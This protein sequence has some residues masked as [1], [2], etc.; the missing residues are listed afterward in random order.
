MKTTD[1]NKKITSSK[2]K[3]NLTKQFGANVNLDKYDREQLEDIRN[4]LRTRI[5]QQEGHAGINDLLTNETYQKD[6]AMLELLNTRIK[7]ML[8]EDI[9]KLKDKMVELSEAK[10]GVMAPKY[11]KKAKGTDQTGDGKSNVDD[12]Q[13]ARMVAGGVPKKKAIAKATSDN[14]KEGNGDGNLANNAPPYDKVTHGDV[15]TGRLGKD[16]QG[17]KSKHARERSKYQ[18]KGVPMGPAEMLS[19]LKGMK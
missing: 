12:V 2:L 16:H 4:K 10:K 8:G 6:K 9:K 13:V 17:G 18:A 7:E 19:K 14:V 11:T 1:F 5:F 15:I 3:E